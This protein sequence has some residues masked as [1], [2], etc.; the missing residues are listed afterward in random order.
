MISDSHLATKSGVVGRITLT[1]PTSRKSLTRYANISF[2][3]ADS[4]VKNKKNY[5]VKAVNI[6]YS[7]STHKSRPVTK[8]KIGNTFFDKPYTK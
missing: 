7:G 3:L 8:F 4:L 1:N 6:R 2:P 5:C